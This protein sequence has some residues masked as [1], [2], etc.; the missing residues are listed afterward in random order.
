MP[1]RRRPI[2]QFHW[3]RR[4]RFWIEW[5]EQGGLAVKPATR[6]GFGWTAYLRSDRN[7][8]LLDKD[9]VNDVRLA[10]LFLQAETI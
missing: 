3:F 6:K 7:A 10:L 4:P 8:G 1:L 9:L 5:R 2:F